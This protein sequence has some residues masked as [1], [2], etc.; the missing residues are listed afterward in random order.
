MQLISP[1]PFNLKGRRGPPEADHLRRRRRE[2]QQPAAD[3][4]EDGRRKPGK[5]TAV[6]QLSL[7]Q[8]K[9]EFGSINCIVIFP[10]LKGRGSPPVPGRVLPH[11]RLRL[12]AAAAGRL[13]RPGHHVPGGRLPAGGR[14]RRLRPRQRQEGAQLVHQ[15]VQEPAQD[16][17]GAQEV[18]FYHHLLGRSSIY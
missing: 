17:G 10:P 6:D 4:A 1:R 9:F 15:G 12:A 18:S 5:G 2:E 7:S 8:S 13:P 14:H 16:A 3:R 11:L